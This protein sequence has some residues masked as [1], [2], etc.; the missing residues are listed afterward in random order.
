[1][2]VSGGY[3]F[4]QICLY[5]IR[6]N[7]LKWFET[8]KTLMITLFRNQCNTNTKG[9]FSTLQLDLNKAG[10]LYSGHLSVACTF[11]SEP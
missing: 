11:S 6:H 3:N 1:M 2:F 7:S 4:F 5:F 8:L 10:M 9:K